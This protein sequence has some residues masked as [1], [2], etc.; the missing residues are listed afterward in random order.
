M[1]QQLKVKIDARDIVRKQTKERV[2][3]HDLLKK[4]WKVIHERTSSSWNSNSNT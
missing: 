1:K 2:L 3:G 4:T